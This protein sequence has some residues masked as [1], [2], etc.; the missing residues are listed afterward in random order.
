MFHKLLLRLT[1]YEISLRN[2]ISNVVLRIWFL[3]LYYLY[4]DAYVLNIT[5]EL[6]QR[7]ATKTISP[8]IPNYTLLQYSTTV[9]LFYP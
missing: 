3:A 4:H 8:G 9:F 2:R 7:G 1:T 6:E 5:S